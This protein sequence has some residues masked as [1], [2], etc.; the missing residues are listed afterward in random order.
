MVG[1]LEIQRDELSA[2]GVRVLLQGQQ[3]SA[4]AIKAL[5][6]T[7]THLF[8]GGA[9]ADLKSKIASSTEMEQLV[10]GERS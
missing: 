1:F 8:N 9:P 7:Y 6:E 5:H 10:D 3:P 2:S 4:A